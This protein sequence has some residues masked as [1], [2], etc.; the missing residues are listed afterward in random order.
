M[1]LVCNSS[2]NGSVSLMFPKNIVRDVFLGETAFEVKNCD[3]L[4]SF[5]GTM[6]RVSDGEDPTI[7]DQ[8][9]NLNLRLFQ[10][11]WAAYI[12]LIDEK[13][14]AKNLMTLSFLLNKNF[15]IATAR[16][17]Q[18]TSTP[19]PPHPAGVYATRGGQHVVF[20]QLN[21]NFPVPLLDG[22]HQLRR[23]PL[24]PSTGFT[25]NFASIV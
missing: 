8:P 18:L 17:R 4:T 21:P 2:T 15:K 14:R 7:A 10:E 12:G 6:V 22:R 25:G 1:F 24:P 20:K 5:D 11:S 9:K 3:S 19:P 16:Y 23:E 13:P